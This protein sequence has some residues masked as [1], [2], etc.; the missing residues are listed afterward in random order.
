MES[1]NLK[2]KFTPKRLF[3]YFLRGLLV[4]TPIAVTIWI[5]KAG[6]ETLNGVWDLGI[7]GLGLVIILTGITL[8]GYFSSRLITQPIFEFLDELLEKAPG[9]KFI[10]SSVRDFMNAF[11]GEKR[12]FSEP[13]AV[14]MNESGM[15]KLGFITQKNVEMLQLE[16]N[17]VAVY[18]PH[19]YNFSG[20]LFLVKSEKVRLINANPTEVMKFIVTGGVTEI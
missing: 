16:G 3:N 7:P 13:V 11:V 18:F 12:K 8:L 10:Y 19:S 6:I 20:N 17:Y 14:E 15:L 9:I 2:K 5:I 1:K 4:V